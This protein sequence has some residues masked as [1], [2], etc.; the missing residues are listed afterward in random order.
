MTSQEQRRSQITVPVPD[1]LRQRLELAAKADD[2]T[3][4]SFVRHV[5]MRA[6]DQQA[7]AA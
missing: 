3:I 5:V 7:E 1:D 2:R 4:A 6:L